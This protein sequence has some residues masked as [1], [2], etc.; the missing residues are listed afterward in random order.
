MAAA[1]NPKSGKW[2]AKFRYHDYTGKSIQKKKEG[3]DRRVDAQKWEKEFI[4]RHEGKERLTF[5]QAYEK[6]PID[7]EKRQKST[8]I[9]NKKGCLQYY[10]ALFELPLAEIGPQTI[11]E[12]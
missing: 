10:V 4:A 7:C 5:K 12:W 3:C 6:Y 2:Y 8:T 1:K 11:R 9:A